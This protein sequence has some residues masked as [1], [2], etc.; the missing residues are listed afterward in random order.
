MD[1]FLRGGGETNPDDPNSPWRD[2]ALSWEQL[3][4]KVSPP[5]A[6]NAKQELLAMSPSDFHSACGAADAG[7]E[8]LVEHSRQRTR[9]DQPPG[10]HSPLRRT[11]RH[12]AASHPVPRQGSVVPLL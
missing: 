6:F 9:A 8:E 10:E 7:G 4:H 1:K 2:Q 5:E 12:G 11:R 3:Q